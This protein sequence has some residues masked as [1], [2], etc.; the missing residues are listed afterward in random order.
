[1]CI[2]WR[3]AREIKKGDEIAWYADGDYTVRNEYNASTAYGF[4][5]FSFSPPS[6]TLFFFL[7]L[8]VFYHCC[9]HFALLYGKDLVT[10]DGSLVVFNA[11]IRSNSFSSI[12][13]FRVCY[14]CLI[15][16]CGSPPKGL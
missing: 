1:M 13:L 7:L 16:L 11:E 10:F 2:D 9:S 14:F 8:I 3:S 6:S 12:R 4:G 5:L 15:E